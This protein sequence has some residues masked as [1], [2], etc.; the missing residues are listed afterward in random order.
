MA[1]G[2]DVMKHRTAG[3]AVDECFT[4]PACGKSGFL[5]FKRGSF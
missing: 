1:V 3:F 4:I 5:T 2:D